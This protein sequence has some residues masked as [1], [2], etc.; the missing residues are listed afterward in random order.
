MEKTLQISDDHREDLRAGKEVAW[1][2]TGAVSRAVAGGDPGL[3]DF[4]CDEREES[5]PDQGRARSD[6]AAGALRAGLGLSEGGK[7]K[8]K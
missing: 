5:S 7:I 2:W 1:S 8:R 3:H 4:L 6:Q